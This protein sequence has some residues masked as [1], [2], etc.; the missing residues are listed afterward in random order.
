MPYMYKTEVTR[1]TYAAGA[2]MWDLTTANAFTGCAD[3]SA[4]Q[5][6]K[7][8]LWASD[9]T[10]SLLARISATAP[11]GEAFGDELH[12]SANAASDPNG[13]ETDAATGWTG[14]ASTADGTP[15]M[16]SY[17]MIITSVAQY[18]GAVKA[19]TV[20]PGGLYRKSYQAKKGAANV[21]VVSWDGAY[22]KELVPVA[23]FKGTS[24]GGVTT[25]YGTARDATWNLLATLSAA[26]STGYIDNVSLKRVTMP[27]AT[28]ALLLSSTGARGF[29]SK[30]ASFNA[31]AAGSFKVFR[32]Y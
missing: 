21:L 30:S 29:I 2:G 16:G 3:L 20:T 13:N 6:G 24:Y 5:D 22:S 9:G 26:T 10:N 8:L 28:G 32:I 19:F 18:T 7:H 25:A 17:H 1:G 4:Y 31:N 27:A 15:A 12:T 11:G 23:E 14:V